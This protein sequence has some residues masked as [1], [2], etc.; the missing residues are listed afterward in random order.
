MLRAAAPAV[1]AGSRKLLPESRDRGNDAIS[2]GAIALHIES[3]LV[4][5]NIDEVP[6]GRLGAGCAAP[7]SAQ[8]ATDAIVLPGP[9]DLEN[10]CAHAGAELGVGDSGDEAVSFG[11]P[12]VSGL[13]E[14]DQK[15]KNTGDA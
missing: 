9:E 12:G 6:R 4:E 13:R 7:R 15:T 3:R 2:L 14:R 8:L 11:S 5:R 10:A 1:V